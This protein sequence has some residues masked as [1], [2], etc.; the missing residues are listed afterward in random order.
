MT[1]QQKNKNCQKC[2]Q[3]FVISEN[4]LKLYEKMQVPEPEWC[5]NCRLEYGLA[6]WAF[7]KFNIRQS[8]LSGEK[9]ISIF[10]PEADFPVYHS[11]EWH[12]DKWE[13]P[14][15]DLDLDKPFFQQLKELQSK[16]PHPHQLGSN[17]VNC[18]YCDD[19]WNSKNCYLCRS[20]ANGENLLYSYRVI[21]CRDSIDVTYSYNLERSYD[22]VYC[23]D[24]YNIKYAFNSRNCSHS[25]FIY[26]C[27]NVDNCFMCW[28]LRNKSYCILNKQ[29]SKEEYEK[30]IK[31]YNLGSYQVVQ[32]LKKKF[33]DILQKEAIHR[34]NIDF[35]T[36]DCTGN[37]IDESK[38]CHDCY[39]LE[40]SENCSH[41]FRGLKN[42]D[43]IDSPGLFG[44]ELSHASMQI[45]DSYNTKN[46]M[47]AVNCRDSEYLDFCYDCE[48]CFGCVG[49]KKKKYCIL[50][51]E[52]SPEEYE[53]L[54]KKLKEKIKE[55]GK[56]SHNFF[57]L[58][59]A[60]LG[61]NLSLAET[62]YP[63]TREEVEKMG[64]RWDEVET[65]KNT[66][67]EII[68]FIDDIKDVS[69]DVLQKGFQC[70]VSGR[71][72]SITKD[73]L[74][75]Y[76]QNNIPLPHHY[77]DERTKTRLKAM[78][79][80]FPRQEHCHFCQKEITTYYPKNWGYEKIACKQCYNKE[81][82]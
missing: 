75:F 25:S 50:N 29:Y 19:V 37:Y 16:S 1:K 79:G 22:A 82:N 64:G 10:P 30:K 35:K 45:A 46:S 33:A 48:K 57:P 7:G 18:D 63:K 38:N 61:Y 5:P 42:K 43:C 68:P 67:R 12:S 70:E 36:V 27:R 39:F 60:L 80:P 15:M 8:D 65:V 76:R 3:K 56:E 81:V 62:Y 21:G 66:Q 77:P 28:N 51:K 72:F 14:E 26:D 78:T 55:E 71:P 54:V 73:E 13:A 4:D 59:M 11:K 6:F 24:S 47:Y 34:E 31:E 17:N 74:K 20:L 32:E 69:D 49:L 2:G 44:C 40:T 9:I 23:F 52:Y 58:N 41:V 53:S